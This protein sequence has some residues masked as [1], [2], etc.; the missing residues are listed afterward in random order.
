[1][2][3]IA[4]EKTLLTAPQALY[5]LGKALGSDIRAL[6]MVAAQSAVET[7]H[8]QSMWHWNFGNVTA[9]PSNDYQIL[10][11]NPLHF[12][13]Y[14]SPDE[15][16]RDY[17]EY[18]R[19][20][21]LLDFALRNDLAGYM[22]RLK[23]TGYLGFVGR[24]KPDGTPVTDSEY[25]TYGRNIGSLVARFANMAP[26]PFRW[27]MAQGSTT[28]RKVVTAAAVMGLGIALAISAGAKH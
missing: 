21:G 19:R 7:G 9:G 14:N 13:V 2:A 5:A 6:P 27:A 23:A 28:A 22:A 17:V 3:Q 4:A 11:K 20:R 16:A 15:G 18:L 24:L 1:M 26:Q 25:D 8:W 12:R 10:P